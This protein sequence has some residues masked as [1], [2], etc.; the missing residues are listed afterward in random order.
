MRLSL[1]AKLNL[2]HNKNNARGVEHQIRIKSDTDEEIYSIKNDSE[3]DKRRF[4]DEFSES[5]E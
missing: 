3:L 1:K 5:N 4:K 2:K